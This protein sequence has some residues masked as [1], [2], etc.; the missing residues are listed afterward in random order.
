MEAAGSSEMLI[1][2]YQ[3]HFPE[4]S[5]LHIHGREN[6]YSWSN[7]NLGHLHRLITYQRLE[8]YSAPRMCL[9]NA[10]HSSVAVVLSLPASFNAID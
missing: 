9:R 2:I 5:N 1:L 10:L 3:R 8:A 7:E 6:L 4:D